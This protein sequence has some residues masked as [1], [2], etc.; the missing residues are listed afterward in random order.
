MR[1]TL[2]RRR[3]PL[4]CAHFLSAC[5][6]HRECIILLSSR[7]RPPTVVSL[8][9]FQL[10]RCT[11]SRHHNVLSLIEATGTS[12]DYSLL[13]MF[14]TLWPRYLPMRAEFI[15]RFSICDR[16]PRKSSRTRS[17]C[18]RTHGCIHDPEKME[19]H[20]SNRM[21]LLDSHGTIV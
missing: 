16:C 11:R 10:P 14:L 3:E 13:T 2:E 5:C 8:A 1:L 21:F 17:G 7:S 15:V 18:A 12:I 20:I 9:R 4:R 19:K 6:A